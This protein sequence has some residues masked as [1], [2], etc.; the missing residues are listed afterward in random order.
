MAVDVL[1]DAL[2]PIV[3]RVVAS[4]CWVKRDGKFSHSRSALTAAKLAR[5][6]GG[7]TAYGAAQIAPGESVT[8]IAALDLDSH[9][10]ETPWANMQRAAL[11]IMRACEPYGLKPIPFRSSGGNG[12]HLYFLWD[13]PQDAYSVRFALRWV[14]DQCQLRDG[15]GGIARAEVEVFPKQNSVPADGFGN[16]FVLP[17]AGKSVPLDAFELD[18]MPREWAA[19]MDWPLSNPVAIVEREQPSAPVV[20]EIPVELEQLKSALDAIPNSGDT[21][22]DYDEWRNVMFALHHA[23]G[24]SPDGLALA[25]EFSARSSKYDAAFLDNRVWPHIKGSHDGERGAITG[26]TI[27][28]LAR[29]HGWQEPIEDDFEALPVPPGGEQRRAAF[30]RDNQG[31]VLALVGNVVKALRAPLECGSRIARDTFRAQNMIDGRVATDEDITELQMRLESRD[32]VKLSKELV[33]DAFYKVAYENQYDSAIDWANSL[34]WDGA[35]RIEA[36]LAKHFGADDTPY[37]HAVSRYMW[38]ALAGRALTPGIQADMVPVLV[39]PQGIGK[40]QGVRAMAPAVELFC[41]LGFEERD[42]EASRKMRGRLV[43]EFS[44]LRGM[45]ARDVESVKAFITRQT[46][47]FRDLY[48]NSMTEFHRRHLFI[49]TTNKDQFLSD[50]TGERRWLPVRVTRC[51][52]TAI[53]RERDQLWAEAVIAFRAHG[54]AWRDA[55]RLAI[56]E[57]EAYKISDL[58]E[59]QIAAWLDAVDEF[60]SEGPPRERDFLP[61]NEVMVS[62]LGLDIRTVKRNDE[63]RVGAIFRSLGYERVRRSV[64]GRRLYGYSPVVADAPAS[65]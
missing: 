34:A 50:D 53:E 18:D 24:G 9:K 2:A 57:H 52:P 25:H 1:V 55:Q 11:A 47:L 62:A 8:R 31:R 12:L 13:D 41:E 3:S 27:L 58:W 7:G 32:F 61:T 5:H 33:R 35:P 42:V 60:S 39:G 15:V 30:Q 65:P 51:E 6:V 48:R 59:P 54:I 20:G 37:V 14:L 40:S 22:L 45:S 4:H 19:E 46:E 17:L 29:E 23:T 16:M 43:I 10:G 21:E 28:K 44:E 64:N 56:S 49:G 38:T 36:F 26:R 63:M